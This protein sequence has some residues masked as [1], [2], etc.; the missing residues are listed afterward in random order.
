LFQ[1]GLFNKFE[2]TNESF[3]K[4]QSVLEAEH[5]AHCFPVRTEFVFESNTSFN[6]G[7][8]G[9]DW[10]FLLLIGLFG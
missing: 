1:I 10:P 7:V 8:S 9:G 2:E 3:V 5:L 4:R 6:L